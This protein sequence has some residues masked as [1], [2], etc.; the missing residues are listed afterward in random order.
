MREL[1]HARPTATPQE[2][3]DTMSTEFDPIA[4]W[5][6]R[7][8]ELKD[9]H[10]NVGN[11][12]LSSA[13]NFRLICSK[14]ARIAHHLGTLGFP[15][16]AQ[17]LDAG[18]GAGMVTRLLA[19]GGVRMDGVD[20]SPTAIEAAKQGGDID[21]VCRALSDFHFDSRFDAVLCLDVLFHV[22]RDDEWR[23][24]LHNLARHVE[25]GGFLVVIEYFEDYGS[26]TAKHVRWRNEG[27]YADM[28]RELGLESLPIRHF[29]Y[30][31]ENRQKT[32]L[33]ARRG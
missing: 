24:S 21:F 13:E 31:G 1:I 7:H 29:A 18:C 4:Y 22:V 3:A 2:K 6:A 11:C 8:A 12:G 32:L 27:A 9:D 14:A 30:P 23:S 25:P 17:V 26:K 16:G 20:C 15:E 10:R 19:D 5:E 28:F 33:T